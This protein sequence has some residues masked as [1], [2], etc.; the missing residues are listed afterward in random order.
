MEVRIGK[1]KGTM[2]K[3]QQGIRWRKLDNTAK[4]F[5]VIANEKLSNVFR[6][7]VT[8]KQE[9]DPELLREALIEVLPWFEG[10]RVRLRRG[11]FWY[12]FE[13]NK[14]TPAVEKE[15]TYPCKYI[16]PRSS[17]MFLFRVSY[18]EKRINLE[19]FHAITDGMGAVN[20]LRELT[21]RYLQLS[22]RQEHEEKKAGVP[23]G[24][25]NME[26]E[27]SYLKNYKKTAR[28]K[29]SSEHAYHLEGDYLPLDEENI[30]HGYVNLEE[31]KRAAKA[32]QVS[33][34][35]YLAAALIWS[36]H[37][38]YL[39]GKPSD[40][41]IGINLPINLRAFFDSKTAANFFAVTGIDF[42]PEKAEYS[43][44][45]IVKLVSSQM[46]EKIALQKL[47]ETISY[48]VSNEKKWY[49]R[50]APLFI[51]WAALNVI[52][53][54]NDKG[55]TITLSNLG[56]VEI[57]PEYRD[58]IEKFHFVIGVSKR[59]SAKCGICSYNGQVVIS[60]SSVFADRRL[61]DTLFGFLR[62]NRVSVETESN[63]VVSAK[64]DKGMYPRIKYDVNQWKKMVNMFYAVLIAL[65]AILGVV[66]AAS[67]TGHL[68]SVIAI[69]CILYTGVTVKYSVMRHAN[70]GSKIL[71][72]T[73]GAQ[74]L[75]V[76]IDYFTGYDGWSFNYAVPSTILFADLAVL[77]LI[78]V[79]RLNWQSY[80]MY[81]ITITVFSFIPVIFWAAG[82]ITN[83]V[84][85][86]ITVIL[87][88]LILTLIVLM[89]DRSVKNELIRR[90][91]L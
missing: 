68:W 21:Y 44:E 71:I 84:M 24:S 13:S 66:N 50:I 1:A 14:R 26:P 90:F 12:Y 18:Y 25:C 4:L 79:N 9:I 73:I 81:Q 69:A 43:F 60:F 37:Q 67:Y 22:K 30:V 10:F 88:V 55:H 39:G 29:Y 16:E 40:R 3:N 70:L 49:I 52:F 19:V 51:K 74:I 48:N 31:L 76:I 57:A 33:I 17:Q 36:I 59:Q 58:E 86:I 87:S 47:E 20:F 38:T 23:S 46:D 2:K 61:A 35:K 34:T 72:Q 85:A 53:R 89:G 15:N 63:G 75:L 27:D 41:K 7:S 62:D 82:L 54:K 83:P 28:K 78:I 42:K 77:F 6:V 80:L 65:A 32:Y 64:D 45:E 11:F 91:H 5:P 56:T 8:L